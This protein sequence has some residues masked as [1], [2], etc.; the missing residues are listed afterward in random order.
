[1]RYGL[2]AIV[3]GRVFTKLSKAYLQKRFPDFDPREIAM[4]VKG[5]YRAMIGRTPGIDSSNESNLV[6]ACYFFS[7]AKVIPEMTPEMMD[8]LV[9]EIFS[10]DFMV[11]LYSGKRRRGTIFSRKAHERKMEEAERSRHSTDEMD[12]EFTYKPGVDEFFLM[13]YRCG[14]C[15]LAKREHVEGFLPCMCRMDYPKYELL[16]ARLIRTRTLSAGDCCC[17]FHVI[18]K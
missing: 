1:M 15:R 2:N 5:E 13:Y 17:N 18:R 4:K 14:V 3:Y 10:S 12:W 11:R 9:D 6:G 7:L 16:G 8:E